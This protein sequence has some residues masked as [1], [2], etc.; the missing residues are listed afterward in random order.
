[1]IKQEARKLTVE[2]K[3]SLN[4]T[5]PIPIQYGGDSLYTHVGRNYYPFLGSDD[6]LPNLLL[7]ARLTSTTQNAC[8]TSIA[9]SVV[10][11]GLQV[12]DTEVVNNDWLAFLA[13]CNNEDQSLD[14]LLTGAT[15]GERSLGNQF[16][17]IV[18][19]E[20]NGQKFMRVFLHPFQFCRLQDN[21]GLPAKNV[22]ISR[23]LA[24]KGM[25]SIDTKRVKIL[26]LW[27]SSPLDKEACWKKNSDGSFSTMIHI[28]NEVSGIEHY[29]LP[30]SIAGLRY[31]VLEG[32]SA[33]YNLD[34][35]ENNMILGGML[36]LKGS[37][38]KDEAQAQAQEI[39]LT[40][41]GEGKTGRIA[42]ISS[43]G[44]LDDAEFKP[45]STQGEGSYIE[46]DK[47]LEQKII[48]ANNWD[49]ILAGITREGSLGNG[50]QQVRSIYDVKEAS[51][52]KPLRKKMIDKLVRPL[53]II[54]ADHFGAKEVAG[55]KFAFKPS[56][57]FSFMGDLDPSTF[58]RVNE[59][60]K[61]AGLEPD[62][63]EN[64]NKYLSQMKPTSKQDVQG[65]KT[66]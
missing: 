9:S 51:L 65:N 64:G 10:G 12:L 22:I 60:R 29:G 53:A 23:L 25:R 27:S 66:A 33:Q 21:E 56:M 49:S 55:Y 38:T 62:D 47:R 1:M 28:K 26:P 3:I 42:V 2:N 39:M 50:S 40:H 7:E 57:P 16:V 35:F 19:L 36:I 13:K 61:L 45:Y 14:D 43:E 18:K 54:F 41:I 59:A 44:G 5:E 8:I 20:L 48:A 4:P 30:A 15:D 31:Q 6:N 34:N 52:L 58:F 11:E 46:F 32:K 24:K 37:M 63:T 17:E